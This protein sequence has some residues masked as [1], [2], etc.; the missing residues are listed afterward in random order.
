M[1]QTHAMAGLFRRV[2]R[3]CGDTHGAIAI[4]FALCVPMFIAAAGI[5][6]DLAQAYNVKTRLSNALDKAAL[7]AGSTP[8]DTDY[9]EQQVNRFLA[10]NYPDNRLGETYDIE[11]TFGDGTVSVSA[12]ARVPTAFMSIF[13]HDYV[14][15]HQQSTVRRE[16]AGV[17][18]A[19]VL[20]VTGSMA[21]NNITALKTAS[22]NFVNIMFDRISDA[23]YLKIGIVPFSAAVNV[24]SYGLGKKPDGT[25][26]GT[27]FVDRP[28]HDDYV[29]PASNIQYNS[30]TTGTS[31]NWRGCVL[32]RDYPLDT[33]DD[34]S[35]NWDMY[36]YPRK[37]SKYN[38]NGTCK[39]WS[40][41]DPNSGCTNSRLIPLTNDED[42]LHASINSLV[43]SGS[44]YINVGLIWGWRVL[45][46]TFPFEEGTEYDDPDW[47]KTVVLM[48]DGNNEPTSTY[49]AYGANPGI[50][51]SDLNDRML[52]VC[53]NMK[54]EGITVYAIT[55]QS[56]INNA[57]KNLFRQCASD[58]TKYIDAPSNQDLITAFENI[59]NQLSQLHIIH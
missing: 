23:D 48:T 20:D 29:S 54:E 16:L 32:A 15:V 19:L 2:R 28:A 14:E 1:K 33:T 46:P 12:S 13:G 58:P 25:D 7:A 41:S 38:S 47:S 31:T 45:S 39:T 27:A 3:F 9:I 49:S 36:R 35:P 40:N 4:V 8:G 17:E 57:T 22:N 24:G 50:T 44:T 53:A 56:G 42:A 51:A 26:Y 21:G 10:A 59:A 43:A 6:V 52:E 34:A 18:V 55:F 11:V 5:T 30:G 37:C